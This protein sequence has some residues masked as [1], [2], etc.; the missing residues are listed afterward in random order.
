MGTSAYGAYSSHM[1]TDGFDR[2]NGM[3]HGNFVVLTIGNGLLLRLPRTAVR[4]TSSLDSSTAGVTIFPLRYIDSHQIIT[5]WNGNVSD[6]LGGLSGD[7]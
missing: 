1:R 3:E 2:S 7:R 5:F 4:S 6:W